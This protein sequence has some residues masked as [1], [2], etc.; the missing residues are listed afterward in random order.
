MERFLTRGQMDFFA[1]AQTAD[2]TRIFSGLFA[3]LLFIV[4]LPPCAVQAGQDPYND[5]A[6]AGDKNPPVVYTDRY[7]L[8]PAVSEAA[9][10]HPLQMFVRVDLATEIDTIGD[11]VAEL[12][13]DSGYRLAYHSPENCLLVRGM[14]FEQKLPAGLRRFGP[15]TIR[16][17]LQL[18]A[19]E[20][21][22]LKI[23]ELGRRLFF[24]I[25]RKYSDERVIAEFLRS[26]GDQLI[27]FDTGT[28][29]GNRFFVP[30]AI[31]DFTVLR[32]AGR[33]IT[34]AA[35]DLARQRNADI[36]VIGHS[37]SRAGWASREQA[38]RRAEIVRRELVAGGVAE[39]QISMA[40]Q[41]SNYNPAGQKLIHGVEL[42]VTA[43]APATGTAAHHQRGVGRLAQLCGY[44]R[45]DKHNHQ[46][47]AVAKRD[48]KFTVEQG[49]LRGN[50]R[51]LLASFGLKMGHWGI[52]DG[53]W[54]V[55]WDLPHSYSIPAK[56]PDQA[57]ASLL[58][59]YGIQPTLN[60]RDNSV[61]FKLLHAPARK[62]ER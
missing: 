51:R 50:L 10:R 30:F 59:D 28:D 40:V 48:G 24:Q 11:A 31:A 3:A 1:V 55:D 16:H 42:F 23:H 38:Q 36:K 4:L 27:D 58:L 57:L 21:W 32:P 17:S 9:Q 26:A 14:L 20:A 60:T 7:T 18:L 22:S 33:T 49:S 25:R 62:E 45:F 12:M 61:D 5:Y 46:E 13:T 56:N 2:R 54:E 19:G 52:T 15:V 39:R 8:V 44:S 41:S 29:R 34:K 6:G 37:H 53:E 35:V 43:T 47:V